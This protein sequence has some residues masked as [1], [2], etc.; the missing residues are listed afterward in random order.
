MKNK[1]YNNFLVTRPL[2][3]N[4]GRDIMGIPIMKRINIDASKV[5]SL[6]FTSINNISKVTDKENT[7]LTTFLYD[8]VLQRYWN[9]P[10][11]YIND[12]KGNLG[13]GTPDFSAYSNMDEALIIESTYKNR[14]LGCL[15][16][17]LGI[18]AIPTITWALEDTYKYCFAGVEKGSDVIISTISNS[19][20]KSEFLKGYNE[21]IRRIEPNQIFVKGKVFDEMEGNIISFDFKDTFAPMEKEVM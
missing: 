15:W 10:I 18:K 6:K 14:W 8:E 4:F 11:K 13:V 16:Q 7:I 5:G 9:N 17:F 3:G 2:P 19:N 12:L 20:N 1:N 21:M